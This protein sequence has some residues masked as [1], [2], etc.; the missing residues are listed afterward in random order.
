MMRLWGWTER[1]AALC[2]AVLFLPLLA[3]LAAGRVFVVDD[4]GSYH[5]PVRHL[6]Q[7][8]LAAGDSVVWTP[9]LW[10]GF[11]IHGEGQSGLFHPLH[12]LLYSVFPLAAGLQLEI[13]ANYVAGAA[14]MYVFLR[15]LTF[16]AAPALFGAMVFAFGGFNLMHLTHVN[17][18]AVSMQIPWLLAAADAVLASAVRRERALGFAGVAVVFG[19]QL[20]TGSPQFIWMTGLALGALVVARTIGGARGSS[21]A[22]VA[23]ACVLGFLIGSAQLL[24][25][26]EIVRQSS[27]PA[28]PEG[29]ALTFSLPPWNLVQLWSPYAFVKRI[30]AIP[31]EF[32]IHEFAIYDGAFCT[33]GLA[34]LWAR[35]RDLARRRLTAAVVTCAAIAVL[36]TLGRYGVLYAWLSHLP[37]L[38][39]VR[40]PARHIV[41]VHLAFAILAAIALEDLIERSDFRLKAEATE[42]DE[43]PDFRLKAEAT[44]SDGQPDFR[45]KAEATESDGQPDFRL[46]AE[47]TKS[48][49]QPDFRLKVEATKSDGQPDFRLKVEATKS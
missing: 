21:V 28:M 12:L 14:G 2:L 10:S 36:L 42:S 3:P 20:L 18:I 6:Y 49:G 22:L 19:S 27:R 34:W 32:Q 31:E 43:Q 30:V 13:A 37:V 46:K 7:R 8:A 33:V 38:A 23:G 40:A 5:L 45:L 47:A 1:A 39:G 48:D 15:R 44:E 25:T 29:F 41:L 16:A 17:H 11:F 4:L 9:S 26:L 24:P 35:R